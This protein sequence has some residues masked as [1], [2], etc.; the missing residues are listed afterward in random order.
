MSSSLITGTLADTCT[1]VV[2]QLATTLIAE[3][4][5]D[6]MSNALFLAYYA[7]FS[8][9]PK[10]EILLENA[11]RRAITSL[12]DGSSP[13][14]LLTGS[15]GAAWSIAHLVDDPDY[16]DELLVTFDRSLVDS[17]RHQHPLREDAG[18]IAG[19]SGV[20]VY[21]L[22]RATNGNQAIASQ[23]AQ[24]AVAGISRLATTDNS[25]TRWITKATELPAEMKTSFPHGLTY[26]GP[27]H[28]AAGVIAALASVKSLG[29]N[30]VDEL[31][32]GAEAWLSFLEA[33][34]SPPWTAVGT[35]AEVPGERRLASRLSWCEGSLTSAIMRMQGAL[36]LNAAVEPYLAAILASAA[37]SPTERPS[38]NAELCHGAL[39]HAYFF[40]RCWL[41]YP[42]AELAGA[43][44][45][46]V[47]DALSLRSMD[48]NFLRFKTNR[49]RPDGTFLQGEAGIVLALIALIK[50]EAPGWERLLGIL[51]PLRRTLTA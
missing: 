34:A 45:A 28:G 25:G 49:T 50:G 21:A 27:G 31:I 6:P 15:I 36:S 38:L 18:I 29:L 13:T 14:L 26:C 41:D 42:I 35:I 2:H 30:N 9:E 33:T 46:W 5:R 16:V 37:I 24:L 51:T 17:L 39:S 48:A 22:E 23:L 8:Q 3:P 43:C 44:L 1:D 40:H 19:M 12:A 7:E 47:E 4:P 11:I 20:I 10:I 32:L